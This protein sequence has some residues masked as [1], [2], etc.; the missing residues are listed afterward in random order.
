MAQ[1]ER[2]GLPWSEYHTALRDATHVKE[3]EL[4]Q[5]QRKEVLEDIILVAYRKVKWG[6][7]TCRFAYTGLTGEQVDKLAQEHHIYMTRNGRISMAGTYPPS[8]P[9][10]S[11]PL[12]SRAHRNHHQLHPAS[13]ACTALHMVHANVEKSYRRCKTHFCFRT[14]VHRKILAICVDYAL[15]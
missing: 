7:H 8:A 9:P 10:P 14:C 12:P 13:T 15:L 1:T 3:G 5:T 6:G 4:L 11:L 2:I